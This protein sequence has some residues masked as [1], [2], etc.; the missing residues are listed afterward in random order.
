MK[1]LITALALI[2]TFHSAISQTYS[3]DKEDI[4]QILKNTETFSGYIK[5]SD[6]KM[7]GA[8][9][10]KD[11]K[12]F[13]NNKEIIEGTEAIINYWKLPKGVSIKHH[14][15]TSHEIKI[16]GD[17]AYDYGIYQGTTLLGSGEEVSWKGK[18]VIVWKKINGTWKMY[19]DIWNSIQ[20]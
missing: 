9:Y 6:Y 13:P 11:A 2:V 14:K 16:L 10:T 17:E 18:Y 12:I 5:T 19:L 20:N 15:V 4:A 3:G 1:S 7:I 8:S